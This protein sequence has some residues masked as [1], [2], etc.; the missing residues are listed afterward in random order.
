VRLQNGTQKCDE[1][2][3]L[4]TKHLRSVPI[5]RIRQI[6]RINFWYR[7]HNSLIKRC[8]LRNQQTTLCA[9][10]EKKGVDG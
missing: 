10:F 6:A 4:K 7:S 2:R 8:L 5:Q 3:S 1:N 9:N